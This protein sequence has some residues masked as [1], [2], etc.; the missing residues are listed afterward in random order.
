M[1][2]E[3]RAFLWPSDDPDQPRPVPVNELKETAKAHGYT[4]REIKA[5]LTG[6]DRIEVTN[7]EAR[8]TTD[9][10]DE[11]GPQADSSADAS[12][13]TEDKSK[14]RRLY[15][16]ACELAASETWE[17]V[18]EDY[19]KQAFAEE[20]YG[21]L[22]SNHKLHDHA[23]WQVVDY[24]DTDSD[25]TDWRYYCRTD[26]EP[27]PDEFERFYDLLVSNAP[28][29][30]EPYLFRVEK[31]G[32]APATKFGSWK[33]DKNRIT[34]EEAKEWMQ[35]GGNVGIAGTPDDPLANVDIDD[36]EKTTKDDLKDTL[37]ARSRSRGGF[38]GWY[39]NR[40]QD[41]P[42]IPTDTAGEVRTDW[43]YVVAPGSFVASA[44][45]EIPDDADNPG[46]Y[47]VEEENPVATIE[48]DELPDVFHEYLER[49]EQAEEE[50]PED[51]TRTDTPD[52]PDD[53]ADDPEGNS[54]S[55]VFD[56]D[57]EDL[58]TTSDT[59]ARFTALFHGSSTSANMSVSDEGHLHCWR[60]NV[61]HGGLQALA[62]MSDL[63]S[64][65]DSACRK[66]GKA[67]KNSNAGRNRLKGDWRLVWYAWHE[68]KTSGEIPSDDPI[69]FRVLV[70]LAVSDDVVAEDDLQQRETDDG[71]TYQ[72]FPSAEAYNEAL[73]HV[74]AVYGVDPGR[75]RARSQPGEPVSTLPL[76]RLDALDQ[77]EAR[78]Y[79]KKHGVDWPTTR[80]AREKLRDALFRAMRSQQKTVI[81]APTALGKSHTVASE[82]WK[83][84]ASTTDEHPV[85][86]FHATRDARDEGAKTSSDAGVEY[87]RLLGRS[88]ACDVAAGL[89]DPPT[90]DD[91]H[92]RQVITLDG[93]SASEWFNK[94]CD[95][96]GVPFS[97]AH[98]YLQENN[99]QCADMPCCGGETSDCPAVTQWDGLPRDDDGVAT[100]D[101]IH[102]T[103]PFAYVPSLV[104]Y[105]N[106]VFDECPD[107][108]VEMSQDRVQRAVTAFLKEIGAP[109][110]TWESFVS[111]ARHT[112]DNSGA[113]DYQRER[114]E[115]VSRME[116][117]TPSREWYL[118]DPDAHTLAP[119]LARSIWRALSSDPDVNGRHTGQSPHDPPRLDAS[120]NDDE[121][122]NRTW[123]TVV[124]DEEN[125]IQKVRHS[126]D[127]SGSRSVVGLDA[128]PTKHLWERNTTP[129]I[130]QE[131][132]LDAQERALWRRYERGLTVV[133]VGDAARPLAKA[134]RMSETKF[135]ALAE[136]L[137]DH[138]GSKFNTCI[139]TAAA[140]KKAA[141]L[142]QQSGVQ[143][144]E[145]L[146]YG[147]EKSRNDFG[148]EDVGLVNGCMD[149][150]DEYV[151]NL[152]AE[153]GLEAEPEMA[154]TEGGEETRAWGRGFVGPHDDEASEI[155][156]SVREN[157]V[158]Q[159]AGRY[160]RNADDPDDTAIVY[161]RT[162]AVPEEFADLQVNG[163]EWVAGDKQQRIIKELRD[164]ESA[165]TQEIA[166]EVD[167][168][169]RHV[170]ETLQSL[171]EDGLVECEEGEG[172]WGA[173]LYHALAGLSGSAVDLGLSE[174]TETG[175]ADGVQPAEDAEGNENYALPVLSAHTKG[176]DPPP[177]ETQPATGT[178]G[179][180][181]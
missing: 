8:V 126:P 149:P 130:K 80:E 128:H 159:A 116:D 39:F 105:T 4:E 156:A 37:L 62:V 143:S 42:N 73:D 38:H 136:H 17:M 75:E 107:F 112:G 58:V 50:A 151:I 118:T 135:S 51:V 45:E 108:A 83:N 66:I 98:Q 21:Q 40:E 46:Y 59:T 18:E 109:I 179:G 169:E 56:V 93:Q 111:A 22:I 134:D 171:T 125:R 64:S 1:L 120:A 177:T 88:E 110:N 76:G 30:Y 65:G 71:D 49:E 114:T 119:A 15:E 36:D 11:N 121:T 7:G 150:G 96:R 161:V 142:M 166:E 16:R 113:S 92:D 102:A 9:D 24:A 95:G 2:R 146:H 61:T 19:V 29:D 5:A 167:A 74:E 47:T 124:L 145:T 180:A 35:E 90:E 79:A 72:G 162:T 34:V 137:S 152:L 163:V 20:G 48:F 129:N 85:V 174:R 138:Y 94:V 100:H 132:V 165:T 14:Y 13:T 53:Y 23:E 6:S 82:A 25:E 173:N 63:S 52:S 170:R 55:A 57:A 87:T 154:E 147:E 158:A 43:Q 157:H 168:T 54:T 133:Q 103:H 31:A 97:V 3:T 181:D 117:E 139:T 10:S 172:A 27:R 70:N 26:N 115:T 160:A 77:E 91:D 148:N 122:W 153:C 123:V 176:D 99:D 144:P 32:K 89:H 12:E 131:D 175:T 84:K 60:H 28:E 81:E 101:V 127:L 141:Q 33:H 155:L 164:K 106:V 41:V 67:H 178:A 44:S 86:Q 68:A 104:N 69:P 140:E 78:R